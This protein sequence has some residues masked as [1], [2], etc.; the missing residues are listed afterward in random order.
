MIFIG[1]NYTLRSPEASDILNFPLV[2]GVTA[3]DNPMDAIVNFGNYLSVA[4]DSIWFAI[5]MKVDSFQ[6]LSV[7]AAA[8]VQFGATSL[9]IAIVGIAS[10]SMPPNLKNRNEMFLY[11]E[12]GIVASLDVFGGAITC[13]AQLTPNSFVL[14]P[15]TSMGGHSF[16]TD[17]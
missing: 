11:V 7:D 5:G 12:L 15:G 2:Q 6:I 16:G 13:Q 17:Y 9:K 4:Q 14:Y 1:Y 10:A 8:I 3:T